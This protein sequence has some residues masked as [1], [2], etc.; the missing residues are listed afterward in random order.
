MSAFH[1]DDRI[2]LKLNLDLA[3]RLGEIIL[4]SRPND[5]QLKALGHNLVNL[6]EETARK[7]GTFESRPNWGEKWEKEPVQVPASEWKQPISSASIAAT[8]SSMHAKVG[9]R[10]IRWGQ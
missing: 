10:K 5:G 7:H 8:V 1:V 3:V 6:D 2:V 4:G 9:A